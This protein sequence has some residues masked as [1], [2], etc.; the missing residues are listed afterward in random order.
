[1]P[2]DYFLRGVAQAPTR[3]EYYADCPN[4]VSNLLDLR[5]TQALRAAHA[6]LQTI[7]PP[8]LVLSLDII[9]EYC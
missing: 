1:M 9:V 5:A 4:L 8:K 2:I 3:Y 7:P 6:V